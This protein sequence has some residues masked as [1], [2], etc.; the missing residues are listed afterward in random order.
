VLTCGAF[1]ADG[2]TAGSGTDGLGIS[3]KTRWSPLGSTPWPT[4]SPWSLMYSALTRCSADGAISVFRSYPWP[5]LHRTAASSSPVGVGDVPDNFAGVVD[6]VGVAAR[7]VV[8]GQQIAHVTVLPQES[9]V[10]AVG[11]ISAAG[12]VADGADPV[13]SPTHSGHVTYLIQTPALLRNGKCAHQRNRTLLSIVPNIA[14]N[15]AVSG[16]SLLVRAQ[17]S[18]VLFPTGITAIR[19]L[20]SGWN[21]KQPSP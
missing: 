21:P 8:D 5:W 16:E 19:M 3:R 13:R 1:P 9:V 20:R 18:S 10:G 7:G 12:D 14:K 6:R 4:I 2:G 15:A 11:E 17:A